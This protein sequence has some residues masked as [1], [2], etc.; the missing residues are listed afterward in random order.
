M[1]WQRLTFKDRCAATERYSICVEPVL[2][3]R[4]ARPS[5]DRRRTFESAARTRSY[6]SRARFPRR[7]ARAVRRPP[8]RLLDRPRNGRRDS[9]P[10]SFPIPRG[11]ARDPR[12]RVDGWLRFPPT[13]STAVSRSPGRR[14]PRCS[15][16]RSTRREGVHGGL[17]GRDLA[18][19]GR[20]GPG[21]G[22]P[23]Q[24][25]AGRLD[26]TDPDSGKHYAVGDNPA[27]L[28]VRPRGWH[29]PEE[30]VTVER[31]GGLRRPL[32]FRALPL[33]QARAALARARAPIS[34]YPSSRAATRRRC[35]ATS[36][37]SPRASSGSSA[38]RS[39]RRC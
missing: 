32:R 22:K 12:G 36:S 26:Y 9:M 20:A 7:A 3:E 28:M 19:L 6:R 13:C 24:L 11:H 39:R 5:P 35:G 21:P 4:S 23:A 1:E 2:N 33:A 31:R 27:V 17:R 29:L 8:P 18:R 37:S 30:H 16:T 10:A 15:S 25:L 34:I 38:G 14:T